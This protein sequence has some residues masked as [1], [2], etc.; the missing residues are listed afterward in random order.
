MA[1][2][3]KTEK[4]TA[5]RKSEAR[6]KGQVAKSTDLNGAVV[7][8][9]GLIGLSAVGPSIVSGIAG[10][11][12]STFQDI[13]NPGDYTTAAGLH[14]LFSAGMHTI[15]T[16]GRA[17]RRHVHGRRRDR[18]RRPGLVQAHCPAIKPNFKKLNPVTGA[19]NMFG[20]RMASEGLK[21]LAKVVAVGV[22]VA[23]ALIPQLTNL[24]ASIDTPPAALGML[25]NSSIM[26][27]AERAAIAYLLIGILDYI[28][29]RYRHNKQLKMTK[30]EVKEEGRP[31]DRAP[32]GALRRSAGA[33]SRPPAPA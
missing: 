9:A 23:M 25:I 13:S 17:D 29:Q 19:K 7:L 16:H 11:M 24:G 21:A 28:Y 26:G 14:E 32:R 18:E 20:I 33:R 27:I 1:D 2:H 3:D 10:S 30:Q 5:K 22:V 8:V 31:A 12:R 4:P 6:K 15:L